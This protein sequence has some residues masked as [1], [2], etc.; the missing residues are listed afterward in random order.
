M[1]AMLVCMRVARNVARQFLALVDK[2]YERWGKLVIAA[3]TLMFELYYGEHLK[4]EYQR[5]LSCL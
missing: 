1:F 5:C 3:Q 4:F 2:L